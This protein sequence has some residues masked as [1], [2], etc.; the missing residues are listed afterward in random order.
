MMAS[1]TSPRMNTGGVI[2]T[3]GDSQK[4]KEF[5]L[6]VLDNCSASMSSRWKPTASWNG[7]GEAKNQ[8]SLLFENS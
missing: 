3:S 8:P 4:P 6:R 5:S 2:V 7:G 1:L